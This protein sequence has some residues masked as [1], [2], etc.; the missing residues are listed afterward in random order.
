MIYKS[1]DRTMYRL[2]EIATY[3]SV[4]TRFHRDVRATTACSPTWSDR[5]KVRT[6]PSEL[7]L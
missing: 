3:S 5:A 2:Q 6:R 4:T 1:A 7:E